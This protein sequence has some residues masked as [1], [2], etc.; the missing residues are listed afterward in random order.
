[1]KSIVIIMLSLALAGCSVFGG[2]KTRL[3]PQAYMPDPPEILMRAPKE[4]NT[5]KKEQK[6]NSNDRSEMK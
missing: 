6:P 3:I 4:L 1:M 2:K 5:I